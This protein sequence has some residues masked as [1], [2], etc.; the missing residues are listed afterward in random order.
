[1]KKHYSRYTEEMVER[2]CGTPRDKFLK[3]CDMLASTA[4]TDRAATILYALGWTQHSIGSQIIRT[5][6]MV[7]LL[8]GNIGIA[9][10]GMNALRGHSN[11]QGLT[12]LGLMSN[13]LP[14]YMT[15]PNEPEQ[16]YAKYIETRALKDRKS[17]RLN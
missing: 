5:G 17:P 3:V 8:L 6:A 16:D 1:M 2:V 14:G 10:G 12:D 7:Q 15:L 11:I 4:T 13:L 9:G